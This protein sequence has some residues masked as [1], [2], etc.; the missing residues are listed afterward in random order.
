VDCFFKEPTVDVII[1]NWNY[2]RFVADAIK[3]VIDQ[4]YQNFRCVVVDNGS[5]DGSA[6]RITDAIGS[7]PRFQLFQ[8]PTN[9]GHLGGA[10][11]AL[12]HATGE[13]VCFVD[14][15]DV[16]FPNYL[17]NHLQTHLAAFSSVGF[18]SSNC[19]DVNAEGILLTGANHNMHRFWHSGTAVLRPIERAVRLRSIN[20]RAYLALSEST[21]WLPAHMAHS[22]WCPTSSNMFRRALLDRIRPSESPM[23]FFFGVDAFFIPIVQALTGTILIDQPLSARRVHGSNYYSLL[24]SLDGIRSAHPKARAIATVST[25]GML[26]CLIDR[27]DDLVVITGP[28]RYWSVFATAAAMGQNAPE[29]FSCPEFKTTVMRRYRRLVELFGEI[30]VFDELRKRIL[31]FAYLKIVISATGNAFPIAEI[32]QTV[33]MEFLRKIRLLYRKIFSRIAADRYC[34]HRSDN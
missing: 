18:T 27:V 7:H 4:T 21:R 19:I 20:D 22:G 30:R 15:D 17:A 24:P 10:L 12:K 33:F 26:T 28:E 32:S 14:A 31:F 16:L 8:L 25:L 6:D 13:F 23:G 11:W 3:S 5:N 1:V 9:L 34:A 29:A 2:A